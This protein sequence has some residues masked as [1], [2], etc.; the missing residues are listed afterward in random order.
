M[1]V[2]GKERKFRLTVGAA[3]E[4]SDL[5]PEGD[6]NRLD[7][8]LSGVSTAKALRTA[9]KVIVALNKAYEESENPEAEK[10]D[11]LTVREVLALDIAVFQELEDEAVLAFNADKKTEVELEIPKKNEGADEAKNG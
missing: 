9:A 6:L 2:N 4:I 10:P 3:A 5:C 7:E 1:V 8:V 11:T